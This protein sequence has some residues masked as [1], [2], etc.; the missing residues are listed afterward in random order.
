MKSLSSE[1]THGIH[2]SRSESEACLSVLRNHKPKHGSILTSFRLQRNDDFISSTFVKHA[3]APHEKLR[4][5]RHVWK[6]WEPLN[7]VESGYLRWR[8]TVPTGHPMFPSDWS[9]AYGHNCPNTGS[10]QSFAQLANHVSWPYRSQSGL[11]CETVY[12]QLVKR[13]HFVA[14]PQIL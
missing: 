7:M 9:S 12:P 10:H 6:A 14:E 13:P 11:N 4:V 1:E 5:I 8:T 3:R 2:S